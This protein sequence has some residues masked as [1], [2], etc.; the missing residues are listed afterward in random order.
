MPAK[1]GSTTSLRYKERRA[2][3]AV[4]K[5]EWHAYYKLNI[6][7]YKQQLRDEKEV[8]LNKQAVALKELNAMQ[9]LHMDNLKNQLKG[10]KN[11]IDKNCTRKALTST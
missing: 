1:K 2:K 4:D 3:C 11:T 8:V 7:E 9:K 6:S 5:K 10:H